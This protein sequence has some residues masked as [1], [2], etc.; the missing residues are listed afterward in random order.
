MNA[1]TLR[2]LH[3][4]DKPAVIAMLE[5]AEVMRFLGPRRALTQDEAN[6]WFAKVLD[7]PSRFVIA[8]AVTDE[9]IGFCGIQN[10]E[11]V[12]DFGYFIRSPF[13]GSGIA[14]N[15]CE[16]A[17]ERLAKEVDLKA[18]QVFI[19]E[20]NVASRSVAEKLGWQAGQS[21]TKEGECGRYYRIIV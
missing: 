15:A 3:H 8:D 14:V 21:T 2:D 19:A 20:D 6:A 7:N 18:V 16:L 17:V 10:I 1:V 9:F 4:K 13:W 5:D 11:G 12:L